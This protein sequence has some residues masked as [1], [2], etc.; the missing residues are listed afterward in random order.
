MIPS[1][2]FTIPM[3]SIPCL[4]F[5]NK[6]KQLEKLVKSFPEKKHGMQTFFTNRQH[7]RTGFKEAFTNI[8]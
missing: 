7:D 3:W 5:S 6:K 4:N 8:W 2:L 1:N